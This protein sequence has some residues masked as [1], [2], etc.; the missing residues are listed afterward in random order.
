[1]NIIVN[2]TTQFTHINKRCSY[3]NR[4]SLQQRYISRNKEDY[5]TLYPIIS[6]KKGAVSIGSDGLKAIIAVQI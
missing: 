4:S 6:R 3:D 5:F 2:I 1:M